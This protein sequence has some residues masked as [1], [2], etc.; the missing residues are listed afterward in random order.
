MM[1]PLAPL[2]L[3]LFSKHSSPLWS[4]L[5][6]SWRLPFRNGRKETDG[7]TSFHLPVF[8]S[9]L[10]HGM[11]GCRGIKSESLS[12][13]AFCEGSDRHV[14]SMHAKQVGHPPPQPW[15]QLRVTPQLQEDFCTHAHTVPLCTAHEAQRRGYATSISSGC[16]CFFQSLDF[17]LPVP[18]FLSPT[19]T[20]K[21]SRSLL[22]LL[23]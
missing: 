19:S 5:E 20:D 6:I 13:W 4:H 9:P 17:S 15:A 2:A 12:P 16:F 18:S 22:P 14:F 21:Q 10:S 7:A 3:W 1:R 23:Q 11:L 8:L